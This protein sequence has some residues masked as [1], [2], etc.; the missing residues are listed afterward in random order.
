MPHPRLVGCSRPAQR[1]DRHTGPAVPLY[2]PAG[3]L[4]IRPP[5]AHGRRLPVLVL[6][7]RRSRPPQDPLQTRLRFKGETVDAFGCQT[8][9]QRTRETIGNCLTRVALSDDFPGYSGGDAGE[10]EIRL[11]PFTRE[12][13]GN[14]REG[15]RPRETQVARSRGV[16]CPS[17]PSRTPYR[18]LLA[19]LFFS[20]RKGKGG[21]AI[22]RHPSPRNPPRKTMP[23]HLRPIAL[24][25]DFSSNWCNT[26][27]IRTS[28]VADRFEH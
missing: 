27:P 3:P 11:D 8:G 20:Q 12:P 1:E 24:S 25:K 15:E 16:P 4:Y 7:P 9:Q 2:R 18:F 10:P 17:S 28:L 6:V 13:Q 21:C 23:I 14:P 5:V 26:I 22:T 19:Y